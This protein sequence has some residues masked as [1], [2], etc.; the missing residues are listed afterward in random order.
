[1]PEGQSN[2][3]LASGS[4]L[5]NVGEWLEAEGYPLEFRAA[6]VLRKHGFHSLQGVYVQEGEDGPK[7]EIDV[8]A[9]MTRRVGEAGFLRV[10]MIVECKWSGNKPWVVFT[11]PTT[12]LAPA[13]CVSQTISSV[14][15]ESIIWMMAGDEQ[16]HGLQIFSTPEHGGFGGRQAF[17]KGSDLFYSGVQAAIGNCKAYADGY[18][19]QHEEGAVPRPGVLAF[20]VVLIEGELIRAYYDIDA[21]NVML[22]PVPYVRCHWKGSPQWK[23]FATIDVVS[24]KAFPTFAENRAQD[25]KLLLDKMVKPFQQI[26]KFNESGNPRDLIVSRGSRG[27]IGL[28][29]LLRQ[30]TNSHKAKP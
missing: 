4:L 20:P 26:L 1:M 11:S 30:I 21:D 22:E 18:D 14:L 27:T 6:N 16:L 2:S 5:E 9:L 17:S 25:C 19:L 10:A 8:L 28:P 23:Y 3:T 13:A 12:R 29:K 7:R 15:G 24:M